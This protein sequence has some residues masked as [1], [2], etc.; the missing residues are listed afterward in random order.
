MN[1]EGGVDSA[2]V[3]IKAWD[4]LSMTGLPWNIFSTQDHAA[5]VIAA[6]GVPV[7][8][9]K[10]ETDEEY[11]WCI[12]QT[13]TGFSGGKPLNMILDDG[14]EEQEESGDRCNLAV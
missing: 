6:T 7:F 4:K 3:K 14:G 10:G 2:R 13:I 12:E 9:W 8:A 1:C 11:E 5:A